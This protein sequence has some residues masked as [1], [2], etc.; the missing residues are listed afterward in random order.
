[1]ARHSDDSTAKSGEQSER[2]TIVFLALSWAFIMLRIF[3]RT[4]IMSNFGWDDSTMILAGLIFAVYCAALL[5]IGSNGGGTHIL[6]IPRLQLLTKW[7][8][9]SE[10]TYIIATMTLKISLGIFFVRIVVKPWQVG[11]IYV[12]VGIN[13]FSS[14]AAFFYC[15]FRCGP[16]LDRYAVQQVLDKCTPQTLDRFV[17]YQQAAVT[18]MTD[19]IFLIMP[20]II[21]WNA[22]MSR[23]SKISV[24]FI[25][26][27]AA[28]GVICSILRFRYVD[29]LTQVDD[30]FWNAVNISIW[31][32]IECGAS[33]IA[34]CLATLRPLL[35]RIVTTSVVSSSLGSCVKHVGRSFRLSERSQP[36]NLPQH[37]S[38][39]SIGH[40][41]ATKSTEN[42]TERTLS[43][44]EATLAEFL[45]R[46]G[47]EVIPM[48]NGA[49]TSRNA[50]HQVLKTDDMV[51]FPWP[52]N[53]KRTKRQTIHATWTLRRGIGSDGRTA[54]L[55]ESGNM[56]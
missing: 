13:I 6:D 29:G 24:G 34:G 16:D 50:A 2:I 55:N 27:L 10:A 7:V 54:G 26:S 42:K 49:G 14:A 25:L 8:V 15:L 28:L 32:T 20:L 46:P 30:F 17:A 48:G 11:I 31:S 45:A 22:N 4:Y 5:Y 51:D 38:Q 18:T 12:N 37:N 41:Q 53:P 56:A 35:K 44:D 19:L 40:S 52:A 9:V 43:N 23:Q 21:L 47:E 39:A 36:Q 33:I 1:M 3:T